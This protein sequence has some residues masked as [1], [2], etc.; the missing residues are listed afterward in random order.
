MTISATQSDFL[1][2]S[3]WLAAWLVVAEHARS[4]MFQ[5]FGASGASGP[6]VKGFYFITGFGHEAVMIFFVISGYL[7]GGKVLH[8]LRAG[9]F[10]WRAYLCD[11]ISRLYA[12]L[13]V[14][15]VLGW[16]LDAAG[17]RFFNDFGLYSN[18]MAEPVAVVNRNFAADL[19]WRDF[20]GICFS[21]KRSRCR[22]SGV[23]ARSGVWRTSGGITCSFRPP[24]VRSSCAGPVVGWACWP[25]WRWFGF[26][27]SRY[28]FCFWFG[29]WVCWYPPWAGL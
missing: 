29:C 4:L 23:T 19:G 25:P 15:L 9:T 1:N 26:C 8:R 2:L 21:C 16:A 10:R 22:P 12:V 6:L 7:V 11:R 18:A 5:D 17:A 28:S 27:L 20:S 3:R 14:A 24:W 13:L